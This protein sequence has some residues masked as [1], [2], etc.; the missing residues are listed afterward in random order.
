[1]SAINYAIDQIKHRIPK[2]I[3]EKTFINRTSDWRSTVNSNIDEQIVAKVIRARVL[4]D[5]NL[6]GGTEA[7]IPL[8]GLPY[9]KPNDYTTVIHI[10]KNRTQGRS[11]NSVLH[12]AF[13]SQS[14]VASYA[15]TSSVGG[16][17]QYTSGENSALMG[18]A[19]GAMAAM[20]KIPVT[21]SA[22][23]QLISENTIMVKDVITI[24]GNGYLRCIL[25][26]DE[27]LNHIQPRTY[28]SFSKL[29]EYAV[30]AYIYNELIIQLGEAELMGGQSLG[31]FKSIVDG[32][33]DAE[34]NYE[35]YLRDKWEATAFANDFSQMR[36]LVKL[37]LGSHR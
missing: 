7:L 1:M 17:G 36:R 4:V 9:D 22:N 31:I 16:N 32:Y 29:V 20:D 37:T 34:Q 23:V 3:L 18:A 25:A 24:P 33:S 2:A 19:V 15:S 35:D 21:S 13:L 8:E 10:P 26:N 5:C 30:K 28:P 14:L 27:N 6:V 12:L 11:I